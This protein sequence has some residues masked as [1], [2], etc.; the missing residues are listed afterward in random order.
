LRLQTN[1]CKKSNE[2]SDYLKYRTK[3]EDERRT[4]LPAADQ[5]YEDA[6]AAYGPA[7]SRLAK[8]YEADPDR[9]RDLLQ[10]IH[11]GLWRSLARL[12]GRCSLRTWVY[13]VAHNV[14][15]SYIIKNR[16]ASARLV[17][18]SKQPG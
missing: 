9:R 2:S 8:G 18:V 6:I 7:I 3:E 11:V 13:R 5:L 10:E 4:P 16:R 14:A 12:D 17:K 15:A 1:P